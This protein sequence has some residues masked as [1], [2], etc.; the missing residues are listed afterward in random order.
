[1]GR[2]LDAAGAKAICGTIG[3][4]YLVVTRWDPAWG[5]RGG[6]VWTLPAVVERPEA[7]VVTCAA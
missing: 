2:G 7:R 6:W 1:M 3:A 5:N 4:E